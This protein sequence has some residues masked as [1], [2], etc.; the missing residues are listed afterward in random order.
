MTG[1]TLTRD[2]TASNVPTAGT[3]VNIAGDIA[4]TLQVALTSAAK[5]GVVRIVMTSATAATVTVNSET[6]APQIFPNIALSTT[7]TSVGTNTGITLSR[8]SLTPALVATNTAEFTILPAATGGSDRVEFGND[9][10]PDFVHILAI[11][12]KGGAQD[13]RKVIE[14]YKALPKGMPLG[15]TDNE[16]TGDIELGF[17]IVDPERAD[18][19]VVVSRNHKKG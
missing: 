9:D 3:V 18:G 5:V 16:A 2:I 8:S 10:E 15:F 12:A 11:S 7:P 14:V 17:Q 19:K 4:A 6:G 1:G 13:Y